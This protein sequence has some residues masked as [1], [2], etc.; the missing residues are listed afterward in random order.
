M[1]IIMIMKIEEKSWLVKT[2]CQLEARNLHTTGNTSFA[3]LLGA[4]SLWKVLSLS[5]TNSDRTLYLKERVE[6]MS[7]GKKSSF[8]SWK[9][10][11]CHLFH[12]SLLLSRQSKVRNI[13]STQKNDHSSLLQVRL[14]M[15]LFQITSCVLHSSK[16]CKSGPCYNPYSAKHSTLHRPCG[17]NRNHPRIP[18]IKITCCSSPRGFPHGDSSHPNPPLLLQPSTSQL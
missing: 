17:H 7:T 14:K 10:W 15:A 9:S 13:F 4:L 18:K 1:S 16:C 2:T 8:F 11:I 12:F 3:T 5:W 6:V